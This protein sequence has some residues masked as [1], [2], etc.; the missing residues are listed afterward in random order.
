[1][2]TYDFSSFMPIQISRNSNNRETSQ[3]FPTS[4]FIQF[5]PGYG[6]MKGKDF[7]WEGN[8]TPVK[9]LPCLLASLET[10]G[11]VAHYDLIHGDVHWEH[12]MGSYLFPHNLTRGIPVLD[13]RYQP[14]VSP[15]NLG[16]FFVDVSSP[17]HLNL[18][19]KV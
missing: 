8:H 14:K 11:L 6:S 15:V 19:V 17:N 18:I 7:P 2:P 10:F 4:R 3:L 1:M 12:N 9:W 16:S 5:V 13:S